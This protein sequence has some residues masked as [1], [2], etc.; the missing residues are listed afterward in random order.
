MHG[1]HA[2]MYSAPA[3]MHG[4]HAGMHGAPAGM[5]GAPA[6]M[7]GAPAGMYGAPAGMYGAPAGMYGA[8]A[9]MYGA[10]AGMYG[11]PIL[12]H[13]RG[14]NNC[15]ELGFAPKVELLLFRWGDFLDVPTGLRAFSPG[16]PLRL[17][18]ETSKKIF[19]RNAVASPSPRK[20]YPAGTNA[21]AVETNFFRHPR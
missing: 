3:G 9:G 13:S 11:A 19:N 20:M 7:H 1:A 10:P 14:V 16:L 21:F 8:P 4:A 12:P 18:W 6:G 2:G 15:R 5:H 17:P